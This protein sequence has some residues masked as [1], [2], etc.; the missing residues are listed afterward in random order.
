MGT[1]DFK[2]AHIVEPG[3]IEKLRDEFGGPSDLRRVVSVGTHRGDANHRFEFVSDPT[4]VLGYCSA[5]VL[6]HGA[7]VPGPGA[8]DRVRPPAS[9]IR[10]RLTCCP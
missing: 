2:E 5:K 10:V 4:G 9:G 8:D 1:I 6:I 3:G 7:R